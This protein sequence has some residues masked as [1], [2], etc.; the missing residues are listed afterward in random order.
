[1]KKLKMVPLFALVG[2]ALAVSSC[3]KKEEAVVTPAAVSQEVLSQ[4]K[5]LGL[6]T[7]DVKPVDGGY[8]VEG[9]LILSD[10]DLADNPVR[11]FLRIGGEEQY[12]TNNVV[13]GLPRVITVSL[14][15]QFPASYATATDE[16]IRRYNA[17]GLRLTFRRVA[18]GSNADISL[19]F[20]SGLGPGVLGGAEGF[21]SGGNPNPVIRLVPSVIGNRS[22]GSLATIIAH[23]IGHTIG[24]R[25]TDYFNRAYS[26]GRITSQNNE[27]DGGVGAILIPGTN[28]NE[29]PN[30]WMLACLGSTNRP[31]N[32]NDRIAL[33]YIY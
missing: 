3:S 31:F 16:A 12:R 26:C 8:L 18:A 32:S 7:E 5:A 1:M 22:T 15:N 33:N 2:A 21:P 10:E 30:S 20:S 19:I 14:S 4:I 23:E 29:D 24:F 25:H 9:D 11:S 17:E 28:P 13:R 6:S 27:G